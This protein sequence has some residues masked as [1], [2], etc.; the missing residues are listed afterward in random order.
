M[1][2]ERPLC[3]EVLGT[4][5]TV[6]WGAGVDYV[7]RE[8]MLRA[9][10][11]CVVERPE[12]LAPARQ[13]K[14]AAPTAA[15]P[16]TAVI[17]FLSNLPGGGRRQLAALSFEQLAEYLTS[18]LTLAGIL[19]RAGELTMLHACGVADVRT[20]GVIALV[21]KS[22]TGKTTA[23]TVLA[24]SRGYVTDETVAIGPSGEVLA[25]PK[26]LSVKQA[27]AGA[28]KIQVGPDELGLAELPPALFIDA[29]IL[30]DRVRPPRASTAPNLQP[31]PLADAVLALIP[32][33]SSQASIKEPLQSLCR[34]IENVGGLWRLE[35]SEAEDL[36]GFLEK[37]LAKLEAERGSWSVPSAPV[38]AGNIPPG[39]LR[40]TDPVDAV[41]IDGDLLVLQETEILRLSG[42]APTIWSASSRSVTAETLA[43]EVGLEHGLPDGYKE[44]LD[45]AVDELVERGILV[46]G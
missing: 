1:S 26:P 34:L 44:T 33:S 40:R 42:I 43:A 28:A 3:L 38:E 12:C 41:L 18:E 20:G 39:H 14:P 29:I 23:A 45:A 5:F 6:R 32:D 10:S 24:K 17:T 16:F 25:Y 36:P 4:V 46:R 30:L 2:T 35:Y 37:G 21:A 11:R 7:Q 15:L 9:W 8:S 13:D 19:E 31:V 27:A 22:G